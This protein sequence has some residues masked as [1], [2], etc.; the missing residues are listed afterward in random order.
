MRKVNVHLEKNNEE[1]LEK[2]LGIK[3]SAISN[4]QLGKILS[5]ALGYVDYE[6]ESIANELRGLLT[7]P[8][9]EKPFYELYQEGKV[10]FDY[11]HIEIEKWHESDST[12]EI[13]EYL[14]L[15]N[16]QYARFVENEDSL[17]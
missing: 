15:T 10:L 12:K 8:F 17:K 16:E 9:L 14:G 1:T 11:I 13:S 7:E 6:K 2:G 4:D 5:F 3:V